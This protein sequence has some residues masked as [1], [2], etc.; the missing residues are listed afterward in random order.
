ML[1]TNNGTQIQIYFASI[2][3]YIYK[4]CEGVLFNLQFYSVLKDQFFNSLIIILMNL[5]NLHSL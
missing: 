1:L 5:V 3:I 4:F 2:R